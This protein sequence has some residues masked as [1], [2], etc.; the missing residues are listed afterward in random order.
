M[1]GIPGSAGQFERPAA[2]GSM[3]GGGGSGGVQY[4][5][6]PPQTTTSK[7]EPWEAA[8][9]Y[10]KDI[11][12]QAQTASGAT[13][14]TPYQGPLQADPTAAQ[15]QA[16]TWKQQYAQNP[17]L[18][19]LGGQ[20]M[21]LASD[22][23][24]GKYLDPSTNPT[25]VPG[26]MATVAPIER[27]FAENIMPQLTSDAW[28]QGAYGGA[29]QGIREA[30]VSR[31]TGQ[32][33]SDTVAKAVMDNYQRERSLQQLAPQMAQAGAQMGMA[34]SEIM[35]AAGAQQ[36][37]WNQADINEAIAQY[38][39]TLQAPW[40]AVSPYASIIGGL[41]M[42]TATTTTG[43]GFQ[44]MP[45]TAQNIM[46]GAMGGLALGNA[47]FGGANPLVNLGSYGGWGQAGSTILG[48]L[49]GLI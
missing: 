13:S 22:T 38:Q 3:F 32:V 1:R 6:T 11:M 31:D 27:N 5:Q 36:Q 41:Q 48:A 7:T 19:G 12:Q 49:M 44:A 2:L 15:Q 17:M 45:G 21:Q 14:T 39:N 37:Q 47:L 28:N 8:Q 29:R 24:S 42:P 43:Q 4:V 16:N 10:L 35:S 34:P 18:S 20:E 40:Q 25:L 30:Q 26:L 46:G 9:P 33:I 23:L